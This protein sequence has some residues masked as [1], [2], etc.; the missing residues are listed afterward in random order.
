MP[1]S[2]KQDLSGFWTLEESDDPWT[3]EER[4]LM[5]KSPFDFWFDL[6]HR[7]LRVCLALWQSWV[8]KPPAYSNGYQNIN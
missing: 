6:R 4:E 1:S 3:S 7:G 5:A 8:V 2:F